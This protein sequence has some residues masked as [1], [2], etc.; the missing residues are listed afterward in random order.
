MREP[1]RAEQEGFPFPSQF[2]LG[3]PRGIPLLQRSREKRG[4]L[5]SGSQFCAHSTAWDRGKGGSGAGQ[6]PSQRPQEHGGGGLTELKASC[7]SG[8]R[9]N[10]SIGKL[11]HFQRNG[12]VR[13]RLSWAEGEI[14]EGQKGSSKSSLVLQTRIFLQ[15][16]KFLRRNWKP[17]HLSHHL[18]LWA[19]LGRLERGG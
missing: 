1:I 4:A 13:E 15:S 14:R 8:L 12:M 16:R 3:I 5:C 10:H 2:T 6:E 19:H 18:K 7:S 9:G 11:S 17:Q